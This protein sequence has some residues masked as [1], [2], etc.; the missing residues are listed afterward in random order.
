M[1]LGGEAM[2]AFTNPISRGRK[3]E[4]FA[5]SSIR[6]ILPPHVPK[7]ESALP[8]LEPRLFVIAPPAPPT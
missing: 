4:R 2:H 1:P 8:N 3:S 5:A 6:Y 7:A